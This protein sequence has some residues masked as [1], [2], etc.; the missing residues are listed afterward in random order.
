MKCSLTGLGTVLLELG[1]GAA[2]RTAPADTGMAVASVAKQ[3]GS[4]PVVRAYCDAG[5]THAG[6]DEHISRVQ[7]G[8]IDN[9]S[10]CSQPGGYA[11]YTALST[12]VWPGMT[13][14]IIVTNGEPYWSDYCAVWVDWDDSHT[15]DT[16]ELIAMATNPGYGPYTGTVSVPMGVAPGLYRMRVRISYG[17]MPG[18]CGT[19]VYGEVEDYTINVI[20]PPPEGACCIGVTCQGPWSLVDCDAAGGTYVGNGSSCA[21]NPCVG[22]CCAQDGNC[23][24]TPSEAVC[25][26]LGGSYY[27][28]GTSCT[29]NN[30]PGLPPDC[31]NAIVVRTLPYGQD[32]TTCGH[33]D[34]YTETC[35]G[36]YDGGEDI[37]YRLDLAQPECVNITVTGATPADNW[38]GVAIGV[39]CP[40]QATCIATDTSGSDTV[41]A[42]SDLELPADT[43]WLM[44]DTWPSPP[45]VHY[46]LEIVRCLVGVC[47]GDVNCDGRVTFADIDPFV[48]A[49]GGQS[50]WNVNHANCPWLN[51]DCNGSGTVTFADI[52]LFVALLGTTCLP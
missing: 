52:D 14:A 38:I 5:S 34:D 44:I 10:V 49:L 30:C 12:I 24:E 39:L 29:P 33:V 19:T 37:L 20:P 50:A 6:C 1:L 46:R 47:P 2:V 13:Q 17:T 9:S 41:A 45:C 26:S 8:T 23:Q 31:V 16:S 40:P 11:D 18:A 27:G 15:F 32:D 28:S 22:A 7:V 35:L 42:I 21:P 48:E 36:Y 25:S 51:G 4:A 3:V 43:Y